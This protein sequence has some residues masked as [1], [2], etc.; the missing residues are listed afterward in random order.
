MGTYDMYEYMTQF[1]KI[2]I[3]LCFRKGKGG[4]KRGRKN[5]NV[6]EEHQ[7]VASHVPPTGDLAH[8]PG[9]CPDW[10]SNRWPFHSRASAQSTEPHQPGWHTLFKGFF[11]KRVLLTTFYFFKN[12]YCYSIIVVC[13]FFL[14]K[15]KIVFN[16]SLLIPYAL[17]L[18][19]Y[20]VSQTRW[21]G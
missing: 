20:Y 16:P 12:F 17:F 11:L 21:S 19:E 1:L 3:S 8:N 13:I 14:K 10:E 4:R 15:I 2:F 5:I 7:S 18:I 6:W 9:T